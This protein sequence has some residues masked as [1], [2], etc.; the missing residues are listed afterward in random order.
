MGA[1]RDWGRRVPDLLLSHS[2]TCVSP[3]FW[4]RPHSL[5]PD[6]CEVHGRGSVHTPRFPRGSWGAAAERPERLRRII[7]LCGRLGRVAHSGS[8]SP[9]ED[10]AIHVLLQD[11]LHA[12]PLPGREA[13]ARRVRRRAGPPPPFPPLPGLVGTSW[14]SR[15]SGI[16]VG[17]SCGGRNSSSRMAARADFCR[18][19][20]S[21]ISSACRA[22][23]G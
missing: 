1:G 17:F 12:P 13:G 22:R 7:T 8:P 2:P 9:R 3:L 5:Y 14:R 11:G 16:R 15:G 23:G 6:V 4:E 18:W 10:A 21:A 19:M 20:S